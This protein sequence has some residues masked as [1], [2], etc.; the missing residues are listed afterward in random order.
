MY[1]YEEVSIEKSLR[2][3]SIG[4]S[5]QG[6]KPVTTQTKV[7]LYNISKTELEWCT[8]IKDTMLETRNRIGKPLEIA[9]VYKI[10]QEDPEYIND[11]NIIMKSIVDIAASTLSFVSILVITD[12]KKM[13]SY[14]FNKMPS[15]AICSLKPEHFYR[16]NCGHPEEVG[17][18]NNFHYD[19]RMIENELKNRNIQLTVTH[20]LLDTGSIRAYLTACEHGRTQELS[21]C[22][23]TKEI[24]SLGYTISNFRQEEY[25]LIP[26]NK[27]PIELFRKQS[28]SNTLDK[29]VSLPSSGSSGIHNLRANPRST[30]SF[31]K[32]TMKGSN[33]TR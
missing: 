14:A 19:V 4:L 22:Y 28:K 17:L 29:V 6:N 7:G 31:N 27:G 18:D 25:Y 30:Y 10:L 24:K 1:F 16:L 21:R 26:N 3:G 12:D 32:R 13:V 11:D 23:Y 9:A 8:R 15:I 33:Q 20:V 2:V 5:P